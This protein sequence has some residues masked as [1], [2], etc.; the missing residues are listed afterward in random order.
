MNRFVTLLLASVAFATVASAQ[1][2]THS[3]NYT[4]EEMSIIKA[5]RQVKDSDIDAWC[6]K[7]VSEEFRGRRT[8]DIG[9]D[10]AAQWAADHFKEWGLKPFGDNGTYMNVFD[11]P[12]NEVLER[13]ALKGY[14]VQGKDTIV[15]N[16]EYLVDFFPS[17]LSGNGEV[18]AEV[19]YVGYGI[20]AP[21][22][23]YD[24]YKGADVKGKIVLCELAVPYT[25]SNNDILEM[26]AKHLPTAEKI[27]NAVAHGAAG[28]L[29]INPGSS[30]APAVDEKFLACYVSENVAKDFLAGTKYSLE[31]LRGLNAQNK[32]V[33]VFTGKEASL[34]AVTKYY[35]D[36]KGANI[37]GILEGTDP[38]LKNEYI[39]VGGHIDH[40]GLMP[41]LFPGALDNASGSAIVMGV[42]KSLA[43]SGVK[44]KR[45]VVFILFGAEELG[46]LGAKHYVETK[47]MSTDQIVCLINLDMLGKGDAIRASMSDLAP[48]LP[49]HFVNSISKWVHMPVTATVTPWKYSVRPRTD[50]AAFANAR[51]PA[52][53]FRLT[54]TGP[55]EA[56]YYHHPNDTM[57]QLDVTDM[58]NAVKALTVAVID[59]AQN[60]QK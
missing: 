53:E 33:V 1:P 9:F 50:G 49:E 18:K 23:N 20:T 54:S 25:G 35:A 7:M 40:L 57:A 11:Q 2:V 3:S 46:L 44:L 59:I 16:Y 39:I 10:R 21:E 30:P 19:V 41:G 29:Y 34:S 8:G 15:K 45:S 58:N 60:Y 28:L 51:I 56:I 6:K 12:Y 24:S 37:V 27:K 32:G 42:A 47:P 5:L 31:K 14:F 13:G 52:V 36:R 22:L 17:A 38:Q 43:Q 55:R 26:W 48:N 4:E